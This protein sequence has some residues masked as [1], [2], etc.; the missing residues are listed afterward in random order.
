MLLCGS[1]TSTT[2]SA[3]PF[4]K[5]LLN[6]CYQECTQI[7]AK[8]PATCAKECNIKHHDRYRT[9][10]RGGTPAQ[11]DIPCFKRCK[12]SNIMLEE[13]LNLCSK[14]NIKPINKDMGWEERRKLK[15]EA[16]RMLKK[17]QENDHGKGWHRNF[18]KK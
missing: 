3:Q 14:D 5:K 16:Q 12:K 8:Y 10:V 1:L 6:A 7:K 17:I 9:A 4:P 11:T 2:S 15:G 18:D 13:C